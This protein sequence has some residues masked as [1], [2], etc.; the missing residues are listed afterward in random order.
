[1]YRTNPR[2]GRRELDPTQLNYRYDVYN[3][4]A[5]AKRKNRL[6]LRTCE[7]NTDLPVPTETPVISK[8]TAYISDEGEIVRQTISRPPTVAFDIIKTYIVN[9]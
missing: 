6:D 3:H 7:Y 5:A 2:T 8:D 9:V 4:T 1:M